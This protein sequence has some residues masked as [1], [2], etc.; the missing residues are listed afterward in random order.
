MWID[1][2]TLKM[3]SEADQRRGLVEGDNEDWGDEHLE[4]MTED[5]NAAEEKE[6]DRDKTS[7]E[8]TLK[9]IVGFRSPSY[10]FFTETLDL[11]E[12]N[13]RSSLITSAHSQCFSPCLSCVYSFIGSQPWLLF[14]IP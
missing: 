3:E 10:Y 12:I 2:T 5:E 14:H 8:E 6:N 4:L 11:N 9:D 7:D 13:P 1:E